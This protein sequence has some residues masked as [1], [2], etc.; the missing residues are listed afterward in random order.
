M[1]VASLPVTVLT[2]FLG[3]GKTTVVRQVLRQRPVARLAVV[4]ND[5]S[6]MDVDAELVETGHLLRKGT[7]RLVNVHGGSVSGARRMALVAALRELAAENAYDHVLVETSGS[8]EPLAVAQAVREASA[9]AA[10]LH[11]HNLVTLVDAYTFVKEYGL[12]EELFKQIIANEEE[13]RWTVETLL[14]RQVQAANRLLLTKTDLVQDEA[15]PIVQRALALINRE[16]PVQPVVHGHMEAGQVIGARGF[17][18][19]QLQRPMAGAAL[20]RMEVGP[21]AFGLGAEVFAE[22][23]PFHP[24]RLYNAAQQHLTRG[25]YRSKGFVWLASRADAVLLW[26]QAGNYVNLRKTGYWKEAIDQ[27]H[28]TQEEQAHVNAALAHPTFGDRHH[29]LTLIGVDEARTAFRD[30][31]S[32]A[33]CTEAEVKAWQS[34]AAFDDPWPLS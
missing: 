10:P 30:A 31:L 15:Q 1:P 32:E 6:A 17:E 12:G 21:E 2:G 24:Q 5:M 13:G 34:G 16:A 23:R 7:D 3:A 26:N 33:L 4:I 18:E 27:T 9:D 20:A 28:L 19:A 11:L 14:V 25:L 8:A 29:E 22:K